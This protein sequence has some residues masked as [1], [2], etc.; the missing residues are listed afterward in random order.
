[1]SGDLGEGEMEGKK[2]EWT[3]GRGR[4]IRRMDGLGGGGNRTRK[5]GWSGEVRDRKGILILR[6]KFSGSLDETTEISITH[7]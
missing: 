5:E 3:W 2:E 7:I 1:M 6:L 4:E